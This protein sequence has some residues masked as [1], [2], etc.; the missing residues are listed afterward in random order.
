MTSS[1]NSVTLL[2][3]IAVLLGATALSCGYG[4]PPVPVKPL[5]VSPIALP[6]AVINMPYS[7]TLTAAG[8]VGPFTWALASGSLPAGLTLATSGNN[9][10]ISG[11]PTALGTSTFKVQVTDSQ[12][13]MAAVDTATK[14]IVVNQPLSIATTSLTAGTVGVPYNA[15]VTA[16]GGVPPY[17]WTIT[18]GSVPAGLSLSTSG[19]ISGTPTNQETQTFTVQATDSQTPASSATAPLSLTINGPVSRLNGSYVFSFSG[20]Q[21]GVAVVRAGSFTA[22]GQGNITAGLMDSNGASGSHTSLSF[23]GTY[24]LDSTNTGPMTLV[25][26]GLGT[27][28]YQIAV[29][30]LGTVRFI[31]NGAGGDQGTGVIRK[32]SSAS[33]VTI[34]QLAAYWAFEATGADTSQKRYA[35]VGTFQSDS[36]GAWSGGDQ[37]TNDNGTVAADQTFTGAFTAIDSTTGRGTA[38]LT[39]NSVTTNYSFYPVS[40]SELV[41]M[42]TDPVSSSAPLALFTLLTRGQN[43][44]T[45]S[46][47]NTTTV[48]ALQGAASVN[49]NSAPSGLLGFL[50]FDGNGN[51]TATTDQN[52]GGTLST[53]SY[54]GTYNIASNGRTTL[55]GFGSSTVVFYLSNNVAFTLG[56]DAAVMAGTIVP[57]VASS[58]SNSSINGN[59]LGATLQTVLPSVTVEADSDNADGNGNLT[60]FYDTSGPGG[61]QQGLTASATYSVDSTGRAPV[62]VNGNTVGIAYIATSTNSSGASGGKVLVLSTDA[63]PKIND[64]EK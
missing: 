51:I 53:P 50:K 13:P 11:T 38:R 37:D 39:A 29:P 5:I 49:G 57:Q 42:S 62:V 43:N 63:N 25:I 36:T 26:P 27:F 54:T 6:T 2:I 61:P 7:A 52:L 23:T 10:V 55:T 12:T 34:A 31:Q 41:M 3:S 14:S 48:A 18:S 35:A 8:G 45:T 30:A 24:S 16:S 28:S 56:T 60:L 46:S 47:L 1:K 15:S 21:G 9:G 19:F 64:V 4:K 20:F 32:N 17:T 58:P 59:Y 40:A 44:Y 33:K 22:D